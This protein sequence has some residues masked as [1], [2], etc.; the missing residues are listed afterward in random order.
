MGL[1]SGAMS[2]LARPHHPGAGSVEAFLAWEREQAG[3][4]EYVGGEVF[5]MV[6][7]SLAHEEIAGNL[8]AALRAALLPRGCKVYQS[9]VKVPV[10]SDYF[11]PDVVV[12]CGARDLRADTV[13]EPVLLAE[14]LSPSTQRYD[15]GAKWTYYQ[16]LPSL[17]CFLLVDQARA[18][19]H[20][21]QRGGAGWSYA[22]FVELDAVIEVE[23]PRVQLRLADVYAGVDELVAGL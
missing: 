5:A 19:V 21:Y 11:Y 3:R 2:A 4:H 23:A 8:C 10:A 9:N 13:G 18:L 7:A 22:S 15:Q 12:R 16:R 1:G 17:R 20:V 14:V 6:G